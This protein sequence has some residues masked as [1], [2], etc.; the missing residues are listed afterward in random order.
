[1]TRAILGIGALLLAA[2]V[3]FAGCGGSAGGS[4]NGNTD[5]VAGA[6]HAQGSGNF[7]ASVHGFEARLQTSVQAFRSGDLT[8]AIASGGPLLNDCM[9]VVDGKISPHASTQPQKQAV[10]HLH[11][12]CADMTQAADAGTSG[13]TAKAKQF[14]RE[15]VAQAQ[16]AARLSG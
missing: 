11:V 13:N 5:G 2:V 16:I 12:A 1:M 3:A 15:A 10:T 6:K 7:R 14:A 9:G 4:A 8:K